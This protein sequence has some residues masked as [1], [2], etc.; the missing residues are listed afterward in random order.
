MAQKP[1]PAWEDDAAKKLGAML[2]DAFRKSEKKVAQAGR[3]AK[4]ARKQMRQQGKPGLTKVVDKAMATG[5]SQ[6][7]ARE[8][9]RLMNAN[10][11]YRR[12][13][14]TGGGLKAVNLE[15]RAEAAAR[16]GTTIRYG[17]EVPISKK[18]TEELVTQ[19][20]RATAQARKGNLARKAEQQKMM[21]E[22]RAARKAGDTS[23]AMRISR[24]YRAHVE[25][26]GRFS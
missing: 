17:R 20:K 7:K 15:T 14:I 22:M 11:E 21:T 23:K 10:I 4:K 24:R 25:K 18:K 8:T 6:R 19:A 13:Q 26:Y 1:R 16:K 9:Q 12:R 5:R 2:I 3:V